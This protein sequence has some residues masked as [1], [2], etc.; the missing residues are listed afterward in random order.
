MTEQCTYRF[1]T[2]AKRHWRSQYHHHDA[3]YIGH[4]RPFGVTFA[5]FLLRPQGRAQLMN[6]FI[7]F[8]ASQIIHNHTHTEKN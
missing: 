4:F 5:K 1:C 3:P 8:S 7:F 2:P 6:V